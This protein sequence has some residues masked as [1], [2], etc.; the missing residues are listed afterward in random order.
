MNQTHFVID[1]CH[2]SLF[3][4]VLLSSSLPPF[5]LSSLEFHPE[6]ACTQTHK[7]A[8]LTLAP[9]FSIFI[10]FPFLQQDHRFSVF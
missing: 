1:L 2:M 9:T 5:W 4:C 7:H 3:I 8:P 6:S 10:C